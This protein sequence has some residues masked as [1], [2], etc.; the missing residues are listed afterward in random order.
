MLAMIKDFV[1]IIS[2]IVTVLVAIG[3]ALL[4]I[5]VWAISG[6]PK[7]RLQQ[8]FWFP[9]TPPPDTPFPTSVQ[10]QI[11]TGAAGSKVTTEIEIE[12]LQI[13]QAGKSVCSLTP[14][15][16]LEILELTDQ[17]TIFAAR[18]K[19]FSQ[20]FLLEGSG[21]VVKHVGF[22]FDMDQKFHP[23]E[24]KITITLKINYRTYDPIRQTLSLIKLA[25]SPVCRRATYV[26]E[27]SLDLKQA[28][29]LAQQTTM[30]WP[31]WSLDRREKQTTVG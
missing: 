14:F 17:K 4:A 28:D 20:T 30:I 7:F 26:F 18:T 11:F 22:H 5:G 6:T 2:G 10:F 24:G 13:E 19:E 31:Y 3:G 1:D 16:F 12:A 15:S 25:R 9:D 21:S 27:R 29:E 8:I 23:S